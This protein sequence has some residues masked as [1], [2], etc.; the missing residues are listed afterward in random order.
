[1][2]SLICS[3]YIST[4]NCMSLTGDPNERENADA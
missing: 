3:M 1:M 4:T 2:T